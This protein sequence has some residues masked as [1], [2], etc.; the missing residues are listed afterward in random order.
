M[1][2][3]SVFVSLHFHLFL[4]PRHELLKKAEILQLLGSSQDP[5]IKRGQHKKS[6]NEYTFLT[7]T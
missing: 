4:L 3:K 5:D 6:N 2:V 1:N 7:L